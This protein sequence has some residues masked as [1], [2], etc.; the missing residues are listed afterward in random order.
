MVDYKRIIK[1]MVLGA[2]ANVA[3]GLLPPLVE[4]HRTLSF[5]PKVENLSGDYTCNGTKA[6]KY[7]LNPFD[8][9]ITRKGPTTYELNATGLKSND[10]MGEALTTTSDLVVDGNSFR[11]DGKMNLRRWYLANRE[12]VISCDYNS[13]VK[14]KIEN[15]D[16]TF[17]DSRTSVSG[18]ECKDL[19]F[20][21]SCKKISDSQCKNDYHRAVFIR[22]CPGLLFT[23]NKFT[24]TKVG[25][26]TIQDVCS[27]LRGSCVTDI[28]IAFKS[29]GRSECGEAG[30]LLFTPYRSDA[31]DPI[32][33]LMKEC[34]DMNIHAWFPV[35]K[36]P[37]LIRIHGG[38]EKAGQS[39]ASGVGTVYSGIFA[40][41][42]NSDVVAYQ[43]SLLSEITAKYPLTGINLD[44]IRYADA[45]EGDLPIGSPVSVHSEAISDFANKVMSKF[46][47]LVIS[48]D[49]FADAGTRQ[50]VGQSGVL[51][52]V[53]VIMPMEYT[54][55][56]KFGG[57]NEITE[58]G[59]VIKL[60]HLDKTVIPILRGWRCRTTE[61]C[62]IDETPT[63]LLNSLTTG[64]QAAKSIIPADGYAIFTYE[65]LLSETVSSSLKY[66]KEKLGF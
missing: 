44:Y 3:F 7:D 22:P 35:F 46:P 31:K 58:G 57:P 53:S 63:D 45:G 52:I 40:E 56:A 42:M 66:S 62:I 51:D 19:T 6:G 13:N 16:I 23:D 48:A 43:L 14:G 21:L 47:N 25:G 11:Y 41:P 61:E 2:A 54:Y 32:M 12:E 50:E 33:D 65:S 9:K 18:T 37:Y 24:K 10:Q 5:P 4:H 15:H 27:D 20:E 38:A 1:V 49:V 55:F 30:T 64:I 29:D 8:L 60:M 28:F 17:S 39:A 59:E 26:S 34:A 36:D